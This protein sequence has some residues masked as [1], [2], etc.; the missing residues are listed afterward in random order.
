ML[1]RAAPSISTSPVLVIIR[2]FTD[3]MAP[4]VMRIFFS[5]TKLGAAITLSALSWRVKSSNSSKLMIPLLTICA[6]NMR[7]VASTSNRPVA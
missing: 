6:P 5:F 4:C 2:F 3:K 1:R 7:A